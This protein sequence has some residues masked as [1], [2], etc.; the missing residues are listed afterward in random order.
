MKKSQIVIIILVIITMFAGA[1]FYLNNLGTQA[2]LPRI[3]AKPSDSLAMDDQTQTQTGFIDSTFKKDGDVQGYKVEGQTKTSQVYDKFD[4]S[5]IKN[6]NIYL[7]KLTKPS[8]APVAPESSTGNAE[9]TSSNIYLYEMHGP[10]GQGSLTYLQVK[11]KF[12][13]QINAVTQ[14]LNETGDYG[15]NSFFY[16]DKDY[17]NVAFLLVQIQD[18]LFAFQYSKS[19]PA[20]YETVKAII[21]T[22]TT[23]S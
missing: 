15:Q 3:P 16:N 6:I 5:G 20:V 17:E 13:E 12:L 7:D 2:K 21:T 10:A 1:D 14:T 9:N 22:L 23:N 11:L 8:A 4:L 18:N 19:D